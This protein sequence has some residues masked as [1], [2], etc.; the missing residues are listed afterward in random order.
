MLRG[1]L[2]SREW[3][4]SRGVGLERPAPR[5]SSCSGPPISSWQ[6]TSLCPSGGAETHFPASQGT[7]HSVTAHHR[8][9]VST[10]RK[11]V[12]FKCPCEPLDLARKTRW[13]QFLFQAPHCQARLHPEPRGGSQASSTLLPTSALL[14]FLV[15]VSACVVE[16]RTVLFLCQRDLMLVCKCQMSLTGSCL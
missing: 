10:R 7:L 8:T 16:N 15:L 12:N 3:D 9:S 5:S 13:D 1:P 14:S 2:K 6:T 11:P 4:G